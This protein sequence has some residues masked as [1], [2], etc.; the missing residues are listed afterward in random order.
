MNYWQLGLM[1]MALVSGALMPLQAGI[2]GL[3][4]KQV[5]GVLP[6]ASIS[7]IVGTSA[8]ILIVISLKQEPTLSAMK[9]L[10]WWHWAGGLMGAFFVTT[11]ALAGPKLGAL[12]FMSLV[13]A[14]QLM[15]AITLDHFGIVGYR[16]AAIS[17]G[18]LGG[19][20]MIVGGIWLIQRG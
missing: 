10:H 7:F 12:L 16:E 8:L 18:K 14:G 19:L 3:L 4:S 15:S 1:L 11:A 20:A 17:L 5:Q 13:L 6:A 2:N 9:S